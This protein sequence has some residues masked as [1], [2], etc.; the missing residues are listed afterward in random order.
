[1]QKFLRSPDGSPASRAGRWCP[2]SRGR[3][4]APSQSARPSSLRPRSRAASASWRLCSWPTRPAPAAFCKKLG[5]NH[6]E[7]VLG[8]VESQ[9][10]QTRNCHVNRMFC[11]FRSAEGGHTA[12][13]SYLI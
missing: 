5:E 12:A 7:I 3:A 6:L 11:L 10:K 2:A 4:A 13:R 8:R 1:M 9:T